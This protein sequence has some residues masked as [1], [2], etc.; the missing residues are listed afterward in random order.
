MRSWM[1]T[2]SNCGFAWGVIVTLWRLIHVCLHFPNRPCAVKTSCTV[3]LKTAHVT[4]NTPSVSHYPQ[5]KSCQCGLSSLPGP[6]K[7]GRT[8]K[9][10]LVCVA[11]KQKENLLPHSNYS[12]SKS[13]WVLK[14]SS[15]ISVCFHFQ[16]L[17]QLQPKSQKLVVQQKKPQKSPQR[18]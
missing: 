3:A 11:K 5:R 18:I 2:E 1:R 12:V 6:E 10:R 4:S 9:V 16:S 17:N 13:V 15:L 7:S 8:R 14:Q